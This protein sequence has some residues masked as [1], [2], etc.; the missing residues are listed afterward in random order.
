MM[1]ARRN[2]VYYCV[3]RYKNGR[4]HQK[5]TERVAKAESAVQAAGKHAVFTGSG[6]KAYL[7]EIEKLIDL[8]LVSH[9]FQDHVDAG[10]LIHALKE[11]NNFLEDPAHLLVPNYIR[12]SDAEMQFIEK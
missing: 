7:K 5:G 3:Y 4:L 2:E 10:C 8:P 12:R 11:K 6:S 9:P 1:D